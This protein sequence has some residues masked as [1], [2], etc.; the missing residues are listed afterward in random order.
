MGETMTTYG[1]GLRVVIERASEMGIPT[2]I[3]ELE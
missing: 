3:V 2:E 1:I